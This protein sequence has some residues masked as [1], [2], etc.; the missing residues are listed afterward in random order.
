MFI[1][2][3]SIIKLYE[4]NRKSL[5]SKKELRLNIIKPIN[6]LYIYLRFACAAAKRAIGTRKGEQET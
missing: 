5:N 1:L 2:N 6:W 3:F 4:L